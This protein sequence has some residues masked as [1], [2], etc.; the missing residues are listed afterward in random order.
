VPHRERHAN[1]ALQA[2]GEPAVNVFAIAGGST[3]LGT[4]HGPEAGEKLRAAAAQ[5]Q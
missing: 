1:Y 3:S 2:T 5:L 4:V